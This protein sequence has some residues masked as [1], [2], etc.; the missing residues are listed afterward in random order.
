LNAF[1]FEAIEN[2]VLLAEI[3]HTPGILRYITNRLKHKKNDIFNM[4][5]SGVPGGDKA[6]LVFSTTDDDRALELLTH[7]E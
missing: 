2:N 4:Y 1:G 7:P 6:L 3:K 5:G